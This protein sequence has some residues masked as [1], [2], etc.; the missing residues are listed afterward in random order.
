MRAGH[1]LLYDLRDFP[2]A[3]VFGCDADIEYLVMNGLDRCL[4]GR[5]ECA[6]DVL[7]MH[8]WTPRHAVALEQHLATGEGMRGQIIDHQVEPDARGEAVGRRAPQEY[9]GK[10]GVCQPP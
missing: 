8:D 10:I 2:N 6:A 5:D 1:R 7:D 4:N 9:R 3:I